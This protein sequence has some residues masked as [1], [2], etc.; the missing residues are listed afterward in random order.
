MATGIVVPPARAVPHRVG[1]RIRVKGFELTEHFFT[2]PLD[3]LR[4]DRP[5]ETAPASP[6]TPETLE[7]F[8]REVVAAS[9]VSDPAFDRASMPALLFLQ[10]GPGFEAARPIEAGGWLAEATK[11]FRVFLLDQRGTGRSTRVTNESLQRKFGDIANDQLATTRASKYVSMHRA[12]AIVADCECA[13]ATLLG[14]MVSG[15]CSGNP[16]AGSA[17]RGTFRYRRRACAKLCTPA[18]YP[19]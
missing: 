16:S 1:E 11:S 17:S 12:D 15:R 19:L 10:G 14:A 7:V 3:R 5:D 9:K 6:E 8:V 4:G 18:A 2:V 13:R